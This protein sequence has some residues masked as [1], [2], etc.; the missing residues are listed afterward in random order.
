MPQGFV[1]QLC[2]FFGVK[3]ETGQRQ[4]GDEELCHFN[5]PPVVRFWSF[6]ED[7]HTLTIGTFLQDGF[8]IDYISP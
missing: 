6:L 1:S 5:D 2:P 8:R 3:T 7:P 4:E